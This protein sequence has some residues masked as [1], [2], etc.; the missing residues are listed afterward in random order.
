MIYCYHEYTNFVSIICF[1]LVA[2]EPNE[3][4]IFT[5]KNEHLT[6]RTGTAALDIQNV[7]GCNKRRK[8]VNADKGS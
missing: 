5:V 1:S 8:R 7:G 3:L 6:F 2:N 4:P